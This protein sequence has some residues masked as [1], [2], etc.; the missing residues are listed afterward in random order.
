MVVQIVF[1]AAAGWAPASIASATADSA[2][3]P[4]AFLC[5][6]TRT[7]SSVPYWRQ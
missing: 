6:P 2:A 4:T 3:A 1:S 7:S 5:F